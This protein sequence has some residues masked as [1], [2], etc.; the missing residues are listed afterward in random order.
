[1]ARPVALDGE[2][3]RPLKA[4]GHSLCPSTRICDS[5][6]LLI[7]P[8]K[9]LEPV[10]RQR[11]VDRGAGDRPMAE[12]RWMAHVPWP[13]LASLRQAALL[14]IAPVDG[15]ICQPNLR[16]MLILMHGVAP[17]MCGRAAGPLLGREGRGSLPR[18][19][20]RRTSSHTG[21]GTSESPSWLDWKSEQWTGCLPR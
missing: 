6:A 18:P 5:A 4:W 7:I 12:P 2:A 11:R 1:M 17:H 9:V 19:S 21:R 8:P 13:T 10:R 3:V 15:T 20:L 16:P 14:H